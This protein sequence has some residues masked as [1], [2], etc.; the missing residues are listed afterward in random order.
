MG[1]DADSFE[2]GRRIAWGLMLQQCVAEL[3]EEGRERAN[4]LIERQQAIAA[5]LE[6]C[7]EYGDTGWDESLNLAYVIENHLGRRLREHSKPPTR[8]PVGWIKRSTVEFGAE[9]PRG[10]GWE[11]LYCE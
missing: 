9:R 10:D 8:T 6:V 5:L 1:Y 4:W 2:A 7:K 11:P 3:G